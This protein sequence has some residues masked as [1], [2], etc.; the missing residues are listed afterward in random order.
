MFKG[1]EALSARLLP[2]NRFAFPS[3]IGFVLEC[4][5]ATGSPLQKF[6]VRRYFPGWGAV[7][8]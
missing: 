4:G 5:S 3:I 2:H 7:V 1:C 6:L 8:F